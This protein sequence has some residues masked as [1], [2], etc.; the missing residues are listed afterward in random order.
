MFLI[1][2]NNI[3]LGLKNEHNFL[4]EN[5]YATHRESSIDSYNSQ[6]KELYYIMLIVRNLIMHKLSK[7]K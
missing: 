7:N 1:S 4:T 6:I 5:E 3:I 2:H